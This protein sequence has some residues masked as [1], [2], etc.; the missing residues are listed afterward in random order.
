MGPGIKVPRNAI[1]F[2]K[3]GVFSFQQKT[4]FFVNLRTPLRHS[5]SENSIAMAAFFS[6]GFHTPRDPRHYIS[7]AKT[8]CRGSPGVW[9]PCEK[10]AAMAIEFSEKECLSGVLK[11]TKKVFFVERKIPLISKKKLHS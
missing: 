1:S 6:Q 3:S 7:G 5:F 2:S 4:R 8:K 10:R 11:L 9:N